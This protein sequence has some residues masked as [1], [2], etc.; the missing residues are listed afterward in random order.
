VRDHVRPLRG[1]RGRD[2]RGASERRFNLFD[3]PWEPR[4]EVREARSWATKSSRSELYR[5]ALELR[6]RGPRERSCL[7]HGPNGSAKS[8]T[9][10]CVLRA[11]EHYSTLPEGALYRF[12]W[13][14]PSRKTTRGRSA[15]AGEGA[16]GAP[17]RNESYAHLSDDQIDAR[18]SWR[19]ATTR[20]SSCRW[21]TAGRC[22]SAFTARASEGPTDVA[23]QRPAVAQEPA[24]VRGAMMSDGG[25]LAEVLRHV[26]VERYFISRRYRVGAVT[27]GPELS[28]DAG[29]RQIT[30]DRSSR[31]CRPRCR[32]P[33]SSRHT[34]SSSRRRAAC[35]SSPICSSDRSRP[36]ATCSSPSRRAWSRCSQQTSRSTA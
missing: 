5:A 20:C 29:E 12:H 22:S 25:S 26:Q 36:T 30:A 31:R 9:A 34:A 21:K 24:G 33:R 4:G 19:C 16:N 13:V 35:S 2:A 18:S 3:L 15:S 1:D 7:M 11:L 8:T 10:A 32:R 27:L 14:F 28:V 6:A 17:P 23:L